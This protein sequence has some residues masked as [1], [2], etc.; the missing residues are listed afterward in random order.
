M[1]MVDRE[2]GGNLFQGF[3]GAS[4]L[5]KRLFLAVGEDKCPRNESSIVLHRKN[6]SV[7]TPSTFPSFP[8]SQRSEGYDDMLIFD[9]V[10]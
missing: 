9:N 10:I 8:P 3:L 6:T 4:V 2:N 7:E 1:L 5:Q